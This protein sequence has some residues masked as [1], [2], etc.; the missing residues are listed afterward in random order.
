MN[1]SKADD[2]CLEYTEEEKKEDEEDIQNQNHHII[3]MMDIINMV[4]MPNIPNISNISNM[5]NIPNPNENEEVLDIRIDVDIDGNIDVDIDGNIENHQRIERVPTTTTSSSS[6][7]EEEP[8]PLLFASSRPYPPSNISYISSEPSVFSNPFISFPPLPSSQPL[9]PS[10]IPSNSTNS[11]NPSNPSNSTNPS[12]PFSFSNI[13]TTTSTT[14]F[15]A[16]HNIQSANFPVSGHETPSLP[17]PFRFSYS[18]SSSIT[19]LLHDI[20]PTATTT[21]EPS[22]ASTVT[23]SAGSRGGGERRRILR[24]AMNSLLSDILRLDLTSGDSSL[25]SQILR[26]AENESMQSYSDQRFGKQDMTNTVVEEPIDSFLAWKTSFPEGDA[27]CP[28]CLENFKDNDV[29]ICLNS[30][31]H[32]FH[33]QCF[34]D[35]FEHQ[36]HH[37]AICRSPVNVSKKTKED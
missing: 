23:G 21:A 12:N 31:H 14:A 9:Q 10:S 30:C 5:P 3:N 28:I 1:D 34:T 8:P 16:F 32:L 35:A 18:S 36:H 26:I 20:F 4:D 24:E 7:T 37:C 29:C 15:S 25:D 11:S 17:P 19:P 2:E 27:H 6:S 13:N 33:Q 22:T